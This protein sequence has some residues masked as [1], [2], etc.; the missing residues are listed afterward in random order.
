MLTLISFEGAFL[1]FMRWP[2]FSLSSFI[3]V[4]R[5][6]REGIKPRT[7]IDVGANLGQFAIC[8][9]RL[10]RP[11]HVVS[12]EPDRAVAN[13]L[14]ANL[15]REKNVEILASAIGDFNGEVDFHVNKDSQV[16]SILGLGKDRV[17]EFPGSSVMNTITVP[18]AT[19]DSLFGDRELVRP[20]LIKIDVQG[21]EDRVLAGARNLI[22]RVDWI[23]IEVSFADLY[24]GEQSFTKILRFMEQFDFALVG[25]VNFHTTP[26]MKKII[27]M[28]VL[29]RKKS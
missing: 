17:A 13:R 16:S 9:S 15:K 27:E 14:Q 23:L 5:L 18:I 7:V 6:I 8:A 10:L 19:L 25:P 20:I 22:E 11:E 26:S 2:V 3:I 12:I 24:D 1:A 28:D 21:F 4:S 29:F